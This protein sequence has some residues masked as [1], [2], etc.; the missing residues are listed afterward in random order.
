MGAG[1]NIVTAA[2]GGNFLVQPGAG[3]MVWTLIAFGV[4][5][6]LLRKLAYPRISEALDKRRVEIVARAPK[7]AEKHQGPVKEEPREARE[8]LMEQAGRDM[9]RETRG[10]IDRIRRE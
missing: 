9:G 2:G 8:G 1:A 4:T 6:L 3:V 7:A 10:G 5:V